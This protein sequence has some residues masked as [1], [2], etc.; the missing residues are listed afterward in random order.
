M[1]PDES[2]AIRRLSGA[3]DEARALEIVKKEHKQINGAPLY[4]PAMRPRHR[5]A[6]VGPA[7]LPGNQSRNT[8]PFNIWQFYHGE[9]NTVGRPGE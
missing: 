1:L 4:K 5:R 8:R 3:G 6:C 9:V 2:M 7:G